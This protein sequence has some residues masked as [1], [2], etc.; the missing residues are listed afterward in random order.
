VCP[1]PLVTTYNRKVD[2]KLVTD[3]PNMCSN[4]ENDY[5]DFSKSFKMHLEYNLMPCTSCQERY[6]DTTERPQMCID[7][8]DPR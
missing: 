3:L 7:Y 8:C 5:S 2:G 4:G 1:E 6:C